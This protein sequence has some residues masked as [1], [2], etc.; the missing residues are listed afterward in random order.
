MG[1]FS[2]KNYK[3]RETKKRQQ[4][5]QQ[6]QQEPSSQQYYSL[7]H[8]YQ[9]HHQTPSP[10]SSSSSSSYSSRSLPRPSSAPFSS[11]LTRSYSSLRR[12]GEG[13]IHVLDRSSGSAYYY[14]SGSKESRWYLPS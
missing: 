12:Q 6:Q 13:W 10:P 5:Q 3:L 8:P 2:N 11:D 4:Q 1:S 9:H 7:H 14:H